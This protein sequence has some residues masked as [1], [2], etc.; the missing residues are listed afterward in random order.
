VHL[1]K[2]SYDA[3]TLVSFCHVALSCI[4]FFSAESKV[5]RQE[6][7]RCDSVWYAWKG[8]WTMLPLI[9]ILF[10]WLLLQK[11]TISELI[12]YH[13]HQVESPRAMARHTHLSFIGVFNSAVV[14]SPVSFLSLSTCPSLWLP[15][16]N[17]PW[18]SSQS[19]RLLTSSSLC[20]TQC[21]ASPSLL[22]R[23][24]FDILG[25]LP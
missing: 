6:W 4:M 11:L 13:H 19:T 9:F 17:F 21:P 22:S 2:G 24:L 16:L 14:W 5:F 10:Y 1:I 15:L 8:K 23:I 7:C 20:L 18:V 12:I 25:R 3:V